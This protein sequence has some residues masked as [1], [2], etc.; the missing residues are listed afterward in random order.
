MPESRHIWVSGSSLA[1][2]VGGIVATAVLLVAAKHET[3]QLFV[4]L[5]RLNEERDQLQIEWGKLKLEQ[6]TWSTHG[7]VEDL[8][9]GELGMVVP[10]TEEAVLVAEGSGE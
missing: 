1:L 4:Q 8:A 10:A 7:R 5:E 3:R 6:S 9:R 2:V